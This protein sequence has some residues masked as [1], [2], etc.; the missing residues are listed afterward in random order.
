[1]CKIKVQKY[2]YYDKIRKGKH[3][4]NITKLGCKMVL[5][6]NVEWI[7]GNCGTIFIFNLLGT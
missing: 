6:I 7:K 3:E 2:F 5:Q 1:M 4:N